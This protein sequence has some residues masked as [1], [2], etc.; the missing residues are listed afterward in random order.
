[1]NSRCLQF[2]LVLCGVGSGFSEMQAAEPDFNREVRPILSKACFKCH[3]PD[4]TSRAGNVRLDLRD[5][6]VGSGDSGLRVIVP[7]HPE[8]SELL[9]RITTDDPDVLMPPPAT[10]LKLTAAEK[11]ILRR[12][13]AAGA[14]YAPHWA[15]VKPE[16]G[17]L[18][19]VSKPEWVRNA[20]DAFILARLDAAQLRPQPEAD[21]YTLI[22][23]ASLDLIGLP[24]SSEAVEAFLQDTRPDAYER[25]VDELLAS[26]Q[27]GERWS[28]EWLD[29]A[30]YA[31]TNGYEKDRPRSV[32]PYRDWVIEAI[33]A[34]LPFDQFSIEQL[35]GDLLPDATA[36]QRI[37]TGFHRQTMLNEE[38]GIDP[39]EFRFHAMTD[40]IATT[41]AVWLGMTVGCAQ[42][43]THKYDPILQTDYYRMMAFLNNADEL[44]YE[45]ASPA[46]T[47]RRAVLEAEIAH[48]ERELPS[49]FP[50]LDA[51]TWHVPRV[52]SVA[53]AQG[54]TLTVQDDMA[55]LVSGNSPE[56]DTYTITLESDQ[57]EIAAIQ[58]EALTDGSLGQQGPGRTPY[59]NFV[60][61]E[62]QVD[63]VSE[64]GR[65]EPL[66]FQM[67]MADFAQDKFPADHA[68]DGQPNTGWAISGQGKWNV[69][70]T[71]TARFTRR[72]RQSG[73]KS[74]TIHIEQ[75]HG[76][77]HT[78]GKFRIRFGHIT[79]QRPARV[80]QKAHLEQKFTAWL[81]THEQQSVDWTVL[82]PQAWKTTLPKL[83]LLDDGSLLA[84]GDLSKH[85]VYDL[86]FGPELVGATAIRIEALPDDRLPKHGPGAVYYEGPKGD[87]F[88]SELLCSP[89]GQ[90]PVAWQGAVHSYANGKQV[91][92]GAIDGNPLTGWSIDGGQG[93]PHVAMFRFAAP[94]SA[95]DSYQLRMIFERYYA[96][97]LGR[98]RIAMTTDP[99]VLTAESILLPEL[100]AVLRIPEVQRTSDQQAQLLQEF[101]RM[102]P[103]LAKERTAIEQLRN[104]LPELPTT[105]VFRER[106]ADN[107]RMTHRHH[108]GEFLQP[109]EELSPGVP[110][111]LHD[112]PTNAPTNRLEFARW[113]VSPD[114]PL[115]ARVVVNRHW[116]AIFGRGLVRTTE[117]FGYQGELPTHPALLDWLAVEF[118]RQ[119]WSVKSLHRLIVTS[120]AYRQASSLTPESLERDPQNRL[121]SRGARVRLDAE[122]IRDALLQMA[123]LLSDKELGPSVFPPQPASITTEG[124]Y[125]RL[126]W[127]VSTGEDRYRRG[128]Y[129]F[130]KRSAP[131][132]MFNTFDAPSG[133][134]CVP[135]RDISNTPLQALTLL[136]D[137]VFVEV[138]QHLGREFAAQEGELAD[139]LQRLFQ[140]CL[141]RQ[142]T[143]DELAA[144]TDFYAK[145]KSRAEAQELD[146]VALSG[147]S[148]AQSADA[149]VW[150][151]VA[152]VLLNLDETITKE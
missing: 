50:P 19:V 3:G 106:P 125:G 111:F 84:S 126:N 71:L 67:A 144:L 145:Q 132:A 91:S 40:R 10:H 99:K 128:L 78:L 150:T 1:M 121:L 122:L 137:A 97:G 57:P 29:L 149:A 98:F 31:D 136:N 138:A 33:N 80:R 104:Q 95:A 70:R 8:D 107:P 15:F 101:C 142:A 58:V 89:V 135:R 34:D 28:R 4:D 23:R 79:D 118:M 151:A 22:R 148:S 64:A 36:E 41:G 63:H 147:E 13:I 146:V 26:P 24:P 133:E 119:G 129:T 124:A 45:V 49:R 123:G 92:A 52:V 76:G 105:L 103:E 81:Q 61:T 66:N 74:W 117:D 102:A 127:T 5:T 131:Y 90:A 82:K 35:A 62:L 43:H 116:A 9:R 139:K 18:P 14:T 88:L 85:D 27:Y 68:I 37:A 17:E 140:R 115:V 134:S 16:A 21:R 51:W 108:R 152:R 59:G 94:L 69:P 73:P 120:A 6:A 11:D 42:C 46:I 65:A 141:T 75:W 2:I 7:H 56:T 32:W 83:E 39:L 77:Q 113:L 38:G 110:D 12:W 96:A 93:Q 48:R 53:S 55:I 130:A 112:W 44:D 54:A 20:I 100:E 60:V 86:T 72:V 114:N 25:L 109:K 143:A 47:A 30:R 87:F